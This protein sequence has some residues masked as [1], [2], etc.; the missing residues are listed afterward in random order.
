MCDYTNGIRFC[1]C[2]PH[3]IVFRHDEKYR[4][5]KGE[6][7]LVPNQKNE[8][9]PLIYIWELFRTKSKED[10]W[11]EIGRYMMPRDN[12]GN[13]LDAGWIAGNLN[14][15]NRFDFEYQP[16]EGDNLLIR[17]NVRMGPYLSFI[18]RSGEWKIAHCSP[19][20][21]EKKQVQIGIVKEIEP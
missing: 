15:E 7:V 12:L 11:M 3:K 18:F 8:H 17:Q 21:Y 14:S 19:F 20:E 2:E 13:G 9:I 4:L 5:S 1:S 16:E 6:R 10:S